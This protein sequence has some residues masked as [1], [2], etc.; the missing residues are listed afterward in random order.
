MALTQLQQ[1]R[2]QRLASR[3]TKEAT[4]TGET[5][6]QREAR[7]AAERERKRLANLAAKGV[8]ATTTTPPPGFIPPPQPVLD[9]G[10][11]EAERIFKE[12]AQEFFPGE[13]FPTTIEEQ[14]EELKNQQATQRQFQERQQEIARELERREFER[15]SAQARSQAAGITEALAPGREGVVST[16]APQVISQFAGDIEARIQENQMRMNAAESRRRMAQAELEKAQKEGR[17]AAI[18]RIVKDIGLAEAEIESLKAQAKKDAAEAEEQ[19]AA[20]KKDA[21][22]TF[23][24]MP[25]GILTGL[26]NQAVAELLNVDFSTAS[27][28]RFLDSSR[29]ELKE[30]DPDYLLK[31]FELLEK[32]DNAKTSGLTERQK[33]IM[34]FGKPVKVGDST[35]EFDLDNGVWKLTS[36]NPVGGNGVS[37]PK[38]TKYKWTTTETG[39]LRIDVSPGEKAGQCGKFA[40]DLLGKKVFGDDFFSSKASAVNS[41]IATPGAFFVEDTGDRYGHVGFVESVNF[42]GSLSVVDSNFSKDEKIQRRIISRGT[43]EFERIVGYHVPE[44]AIKKKDLIISQIK[45]GKITPSEISKAVDQ[46]DE[47]GWS[48]QLNQ[49]LNDPS[50]KPIS[51][52]Q[53]EKIKSDLG[54]TQGMA[55]ELIRKRTVLGFGNE[56]FQTFKD[57]KVSALQTFIDTETELIQLRKDWEAL[58]AES[59][60]APFEG[61]L[62]K[63]ART[64]SRA[65]RFAG[66]ADPTEELRLY[67]DIERRA[68]KKLVEFIQEI[69]GAAVSEPEFQRLAKLLPNVNMTSTQFE[70]ALKDSEKENIRAQEAIAG[71]YGFDSITEFKEALQN[72]GAMPRNLESARFEVTT[73]WGKEG[74]TNTLDSTYS[75]SFSNPR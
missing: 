25:A 29:A 50:N 37:F 49:T 26:D 54:I 17:A 62:D 1:R 41:N 74:Y 33:T 60:T 18:T 45:S 3:R 28:L 22:D 38:G 6:E 48:V 39:D 14:I 71:R 70:A 67:E 43:P 13:K 69:S 35:Y 30:S 65:L 27:M 32:F 34:Q 7:A 2:Q 61:P 47:E 15:S 58:K 51:D 36:G 59:D 10:R 9:P 53:A 73:E 68:G 20:F 64:V 55:N 75:N 44:T 23:E 56:Q 52:S 40:N 11:T 5:P 66:I 8:A 72:Y 12:Q 63:G 19:A 16:G 42:D 21:F 46:A 57:E 24:S 31:K 4:Q